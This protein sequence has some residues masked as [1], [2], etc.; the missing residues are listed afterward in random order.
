MLDDILRVELLN[1]VYVPNCSALVNQVSNRRELMKELLW[2][3]WF[4]R[5]PIR[6]V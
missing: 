3:F 2:C 5:V 6:V 4:G 1:D